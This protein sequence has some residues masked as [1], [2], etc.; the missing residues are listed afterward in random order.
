MI[1]DDIQRLKKRLFF[2]LIVLYEIIQEGLDVCP[3]NV[4]SF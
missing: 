2:H 4:T 3:N 1:N